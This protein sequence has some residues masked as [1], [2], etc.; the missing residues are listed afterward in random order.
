MNLEGSSFPSYLS[1]AK[2]L[3][4]QPGKRTWKSQHVSGLVEEVIEVTKSFICLTQAELRRELGLGKLLK[5]HTA[6]VPTISMLNEKGVPEDFYCFVDAAQPYRSCSFKS[7]QKASWSVDH[8]AA[9]AQ[10]FAKHGE[11]MLKDVTLQQGNSSGMSACLASTGI[12]SLSEYVE[13]VKADE[14]NPEADGENLDDDDDEMCVGGLGAGGGFVGAAAASVSFTPDPSEASGSAKKQKRSKSFSSPAPDQ[15]SV[16]AASTQGLDE[17]EDDA[18]L[19]GASTLLEGDDLHF[20][21]GG[22]SKY[23]FSPTNGDPTTWKAKLP[24]Q[25]I[26]DKAAKKGRTLESMKRQLARMEKPT[27]KYHLHCGVL[28]NYIRMCDIATDLAK[29][30]SYS[31]IPDDD[32]LRMLDAMAAEKVTLPVDVKKKILQ[33]HL[34]LLVKVSDWPKMV[35]ALNPFLTSAWDNTKPNVSSLPVSEG[36]MLATFEH[37]FWTTMLKPKLSQGVSEVKEL[38]SIA[39]V[40][41]Q[42]LD[43]VDTIELSTLAAGCRANI[44]S[45]C[46]CL[47]ALSQDCVDTRY[48]AS[49]SR[50][51][52][53]VGKTSKSWLVEVAAFIDTSEYWGMKL[54]T[55][56]KDVAAQLESEESLTSALDALDSVSTPSA[57]V[58]D[59]VVTALDKFPEW[60]Q[61][62]R[63]IAIQNMETLVVEKLGALVEAT[64]EQ[65]GMDLSTLD[66]LLAA[67]HISL[68]LH[69][70]VA[71][72]KEKVAG[73][74]ASRK[75]ALVEAELLS[76]SGNMQQKQKVHDML[77]DMS[78]FAE[79]A[80]TLS[81]PLTS[82]AMEN[83]HALLSAILGKVDSYL[84]QTKGASQ[85]A[86]MR[87]F[88]YFLEHVGKCF[89]MQEQEAWSAFAPSWDALLEVHSKLRT[90]MPVSEPGVAASSD[91]EA[92]HPTLA[93]LK[94]CRGLELKLQTCQADVLK[95]KWPESVNKGPFT[96]TCA[97][98]LKQLETEIGKELDW[99]KTR[100][101][102]TV[103]KQV[104]LLNKYTLKGKQWK[105][106]ATSCKSWTSLLKLAKETILTLNPEEVDPARKAL[107]EVL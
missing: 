58:V 19:D 77:E 107:D 71:G 72:M 59:K 29:K 92:N 83:I 67:A 76:M 85:E 39:K 25:V 53:H 11:E 61:S 56:T 3:D 5:C 55:F 66:P 48:Q 2:K 50:V 80:V 1:E 43:E 33:R 38:R 10:Q 34:D 47:L 98:L 75:Q 46:E 96:T 13:K 78:L 41:L 81:R 97:A 32:L 49:V 37:I 44:I 6:G 79:K 20:G 15:E 88:V 65:E 94:Q 54:K 95:A 93:S 4:A 9:S 18:G 82:A 103:N 36:V 105:T 60:R 100:L 28:R 104:A 89:T 51:H 73:A 22:K 52:L 101:T 68:P 91:G 7:L 42:A 63:P 99:W 16:P 31:S 23:M 74:L 35:Q 64:V 30:E 90:L 24:I 8:M 70:D 12:C 40:T 26:I 45:V 21:D 17:E 106:D 69:P 84:Q 62:L 86:D 57:D 102:V 14:A 87:K 27:N